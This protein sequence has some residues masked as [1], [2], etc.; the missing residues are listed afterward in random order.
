MK[1]VC[2]LPTYNERES[3]TLLLDALDDVLKKYNA[4]F[5]VIDDNSPDG[6]YEEVK[7]YQ[8]QNS[9]VYC[10]TGKKEGLGKALLR[11]MDYAVETLH[12]DVIVQMDAD[13]SHDPVAI[14]EFLSKFEKG[15]DFVVGS[16][17]I[18]GGSI[19]ENW[20]L[21]RKI[22]SRIGNAIVRFGLGILRIH[23]WTGGFRAYKA[24]YAQKISG[25]VRRYNGYI[26]Q[27]AFLYKSFLTGASISEVPISFTDRRYGKSKIMVGE[28][29]F[30]IFEFIVRER[31]KRIRHGPFGKFLVV[32]TVGFIINTVL[33]EIFVIIGL[34]PWFGGIIGAECAI[35]SNFLLNNAWTFKSRKATGLRKV[36]KF[37]QFNLSSIGAI[38]IQGGT[39][40]VG[41]MF[42]GVST[43]RWWYLIGVGIG[44]FWNY[45][46]Y[47]RVIWRRI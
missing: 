39:I 43:Y 13:L 12:A 35:I 17:Y 14:P 5:L 28:Y 21:H 41:T 30:S 45:M 18:P 6:T 32:G 20:G 34:A 33:L 9:R 15:Y 42:F 47:S 24:V 22:Y 16:R 11:G 40:F 3:I 8:K 26:F 36:S 2:L 23:D 29:I 46:M 19:P 1:I 37:F 10:I 27:I 38:I 25:S 44:M 31:W 7:K 4:L